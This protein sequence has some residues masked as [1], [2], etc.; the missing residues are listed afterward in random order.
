MRAYSTP[1]DL[2]EAWCERRQTVSPCDTKWGWVL[3]ALRAGARDEM[4]AKALQ[5][6]QQPNRI[7]YEK[8]LAVLGR[9]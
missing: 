6:V 3:A 5:V 7:R 1:T 4:R 9:R 8:P 2:K